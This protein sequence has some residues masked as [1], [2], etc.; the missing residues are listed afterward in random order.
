MNA[1]GWSASP[2]A[3]VEGVALIRAIGGWMY[4]RN[5]KQI[6]PQRRTR[7]GGWLQ[8]LITS[9]L[10]TSTTP[11][12]SKTIMIYTWPLQVTPPS[13]PPPAA[14]ATAG[15]GGSEHL[16]PS[17]LASGRSPEVWHRCQISTVSQDKNERR[18]SGKTINRNSFN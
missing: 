12:E 11:E 6:P 3:A 5:Q 8:R 1:D 18:L 7:D 16:R 10:T 17:S 13:F 15:G 2:S 14:V 4:G 9:L